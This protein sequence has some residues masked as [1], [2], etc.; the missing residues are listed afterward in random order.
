MSEIPGAT[1][2]AM[3]D[4]IIGGDPVK[5]R[6]AD[7]THGY[8]SGTDVFMADISGGSLLGS[9]LDLAETTTTD[10]E[11]TSA[12][13]SLGSISSGIFVDALFV[14][15]DTGSDATDRILAFIDTNSDGT[16][17]LKEGD[18]GTMTVVF[19]SNVVFRI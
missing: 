15:R 12:G 2:K 11:V 10:G 4:A 14:F 7:N 1:L 19:P 16:D 5:C 9:E 3:L 18:G 8:V 17:M 6:A 13:G